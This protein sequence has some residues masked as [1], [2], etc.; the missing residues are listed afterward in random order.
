[1]Q[2][3]GLTH[4]GFYKHFADK[5]QLLQEAVAN[6]LAKVAA[7]IEALT[8]GLPRGEALSEVIRF[9]LSEEHLRNPDLGCALA[10]L[11]TELGRM[12][13]A[14]KNE[15][16]RALDAYADRLDFLLPGSSAQQRRA[17]FLV[18]FPAMAGCMMAARAYGSKQ[19]QQQIL[20]AG[21]MFFQQAFCG[22]SNPSF[23]RG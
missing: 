17:G 15:I 8:R 11:G 2:A 5:D 9:Y 13:Q 12:P 3:A 10:A 20:S 22:D 23:P 21:R 19:R 6:A 18:L 1:M 16:S 14:M 7:Q 4:G